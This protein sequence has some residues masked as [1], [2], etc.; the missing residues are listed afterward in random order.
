MA[1][2]PAPRRTARRVGLALA[3]V[4]G[5]L[6]AGVP[7][8]ATPGDP[9]TSAEAAEVVAAKGHELEVVTEQF[10]E[11]REAFEGRGSRASPAP[12]TPASR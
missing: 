1:T 10:N 3:A 12:P 8:Q 7:A 5:I 9:T 4:V 11:A 6:F 2:A